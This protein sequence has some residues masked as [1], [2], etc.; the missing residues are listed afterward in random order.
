M[1]KIF[2]CGLLLLPFWTSTVFGQGSF[3][4]RLTGYQFF[5]DTVA[6]NNGGAKVVASGRLRRSGLNIAFR[7]ITIGATDSLRI[8]VQ[9][10]GYMTKTPPDSGNWLTI[11]NFGWKTTVG[12]T[13]LRLP[14]GAAARDSFLSPLRYIRVLSEHSVGTPQT[15]DTSRWNL[16]LQEWGDPVD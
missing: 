4:H 3:E 12:N 11:S 1:K 6:A 15:T 10:A 7:L 13:T 8:T 5:K 14:T 16:Y 2:L 9:T